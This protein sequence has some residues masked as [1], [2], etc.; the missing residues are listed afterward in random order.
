MRP[1]LTLQSLI[2]QLGKEAL[3]QTGTNE[4]EKRQASSIGGQAPEVQ[5]QFIQTAL[6]LLDESP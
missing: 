5:R 6:S 3:L 4:K 2:E 1:N